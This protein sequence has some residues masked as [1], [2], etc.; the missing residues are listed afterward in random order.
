MGSFQ[1]GKQAE[2][3]AAKF[4]ENNGYNVIERNFRTR[5]GEIDIVATEEDTLVF[6]EV[7]FRRSKDFGLPEETINSRKIQK[8][9]NTAYRY[10]SMKNPHFS[11]I[12]FD[13]IAVDTEGVRHIKNAFEAEI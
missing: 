3:M 10:I 6:V 9:V 2:E 12:R 8:I 13:V 4:L 11:D 5:F 7:R 1:T